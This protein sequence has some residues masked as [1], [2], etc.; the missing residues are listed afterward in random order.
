MMTATLTL[1]PEIKSPKCPIAG[2]EEPPF[3]RL[4]QRMQ[5]SHIFCNI[6]RDTVACMVAKRDYEDFI[7][8]LRE[9]GIT[10][11]PVFSDIIDIEQRK[12][13]ISRCTN[14]GKHAGLNFEPYR[15]GNVWVC[16]THARI[17]QYVAQR[18]N[19]LRVLHELEQKSR[20][21]DPERKKRSRAIQHACAR[22]KESRNY[23]ES[24]CRD[25]QRDRIKMPQRWLAAWAQINFR[26]EPT[27]WFDAYQNRI[28]RSRIQK[29]ISKIGKLRIRNSR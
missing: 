28:A 15:R 27:S 2:C 7:N 13:G 29:Y 22:H 6:H 3:D 25:L 23:S 9:E 20:V 1:R 5:V 19:G 11:E 12:C 16:E 24:V 26:V 18:L 17:V 14:D 10:G 21:Q 8:R 4:P